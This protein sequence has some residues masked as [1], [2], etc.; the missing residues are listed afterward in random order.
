LKHRFIGLF[1]ILAALLSLTWWMNRLIQPEEI[2]QPAVGRYPDAYADALVVRTYDEQG[3]LKQR[4]RSQRM[5]FYKEEG[6]TE[7]RQPMLWHYNQKGPPVQMR[8]REGLIR[9]D[10]ETLHLSGPVTIDRP[11]GA[12]TAPLHIVTQDLTLHFDDT[13]A[14]TDGPV[15]IESDEYWMTATGMEAWLK[16]P[17]RLKLLHEVRGYYEFQ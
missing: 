6:V 12:D 13:F 14:T 8:A 7:L 3:G 1:F 2:R 10:E 9:S 11:T 17:L 5:R 16:A 15:R 4:L